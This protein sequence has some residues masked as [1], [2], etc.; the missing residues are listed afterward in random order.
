MISLTSL[1]NMYKENDFMF[2]LY[3]SLGLLLIL[4]AY[5]FITRKKGTWTNRVTDYGKLMPTNANLV[6]ATNINNNNNIR[7]RPPTLSKGEIECRRVVEKIFR[8][9]FPKCRPDFLRNSVTSD[10]FNNNNLEIDCYNDE[11]KIGI[12]YNGVQHYKY[13]P[14]FHKNKEAFYNQKYRD[15]MKRVKCQQNGIL[16]I[17]VP[18][19]IQVENIEE[20]IKSKLTLKN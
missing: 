20:Y 16:L 13:I 2:F 3:L 6:L 5:N 10:D 18:Y 17:E 15:E 4:F 7:R 8:R 1:I 14:F 12:E 11:L 19:S 9:P